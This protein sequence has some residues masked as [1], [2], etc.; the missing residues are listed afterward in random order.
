MSTT[1][2]REGRRVVVTGMGVT[3]PI[4]HSVDETVGALREGRHGIRRMPEWDHMADLQCRIGA[5][6][7]GL[8]L[9]ARYHRR[10]RRTM[11]RVALLAL[12]ASEQAVGQA[13]LDE[14]LLSNGHTGVAYGSTSGSSIELE[15]FST[16]LVMEKSMRGLESNAYLRIMAHTCAANMANH[17]KVRGRVIPTCSACTSSSQAIGVGYEQIRYGGAD[18]MLC[19][20]AEEM[21]YTTAVT[22]DLLMA[23]STHFNDLPD[24]SP[25]PFDAARDGLVVGEGAATVI[26]EELEHAQRRAAPI[27]AEVLGYGN[28]CDGVHF[29][30]PSP[31]GMRKVMELSLADAR[32][33]PDDVDYVNAHGTGTPVGDVAES[34]ATWD[35]FR[36]AIPVSTQKSYV[37][38]TLGACG[39]V[40]AIWTIRMMQGGFI[41]PNRNLGTVDPEC[42]ELDY[43]RELREQLIRVAMT[44]NFAF[45]GINTSLVLGPPP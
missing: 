29:T 45:G 39:A 7:E 16:P 20:G 28:N 18:V 25:R 40:E 42:A 26:L 3:T 21:H 24:E 33:S 37:G 8:D 36:R 43:V 23:T 38:H 35:L 1:Q 27:L 12:H 32:L 15:K 10:V 41:I 4:G 2:K 19:G 34:R 11:G 13:K 17:F 9:T 22:F 31:D 14:E 30:N 5:T 6:V 44:N